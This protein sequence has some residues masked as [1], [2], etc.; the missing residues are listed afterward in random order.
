MPNDKVSLRQLLAL[1]FAG[2]LSPAVAALPGET[3]AAAGS[4]AWLAPLF[5][6][7]VILAVCWVVW[8]IFR[9]L[10]GDA[11]LAEALEA[12]F[13]AV[14]GRIATGVYLLWCLFILVYQA[15]LYGQRLIVAGYREAS[16]GFF[17]AALLGLALWLGLGKL[18]AFARA[19]EIFCMALLAALLGAVFFSI[20]NVKITYVLPL[21]VEDAPGIAASA[22]PVFRVLSY[23]VFA[24]FLGGRVTRRASD[25]RRSVRWTIAFCAVIMLLLLTI[26]GQFGPKLTAVMEAPFFKMVEGIGI[27]GA[28]QRLEAVAAALWALSDLTLIGLLLFSCRFMLASL[29]RLKKSNLTVV[30][31]VL[32]TFFGALA[33]SYA[34]Q[35]A[36]TAAVIG[37]IGS[38]ILSFGALPLVLLALRVR[39]G[40]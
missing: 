3:A 30:P 9:M 40:A 7:P 21:W 35:L 33:F 26:L 8:A 10:P 4:G 16:F 31:V 19:G 20:Y 17:L 1:L 14:A 11:G 24:A 28:F 27:R 25:V 34:P 13:G 2:L 29:F 15:R 12:A 37:Q 39:K 22:V 5:A 23:A 38:I 36:E 18:A 32:I 6:L